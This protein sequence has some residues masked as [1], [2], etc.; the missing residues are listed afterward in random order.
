MGCAL[1][2]HGGRGGGEGIKEH[3][4]SCRGLGLRCG[5][6]SPAPCLHWGAAGA[7][8]GA[9][10]GC[11]AVV[12][13]L[14]GWVLPG[15]GWRQGWHSSGWVLAWLIQVFI[16]ASLTCLGK[17]ATGKRFAAGSIRAA[18]TASAA[19]VSNACVA[20]RHCSVKES[21]FPL[22]LLAAGSPF[23]DDVPCVTATSLC[24][25]SCVREDPRLRSRPLL[26]SPAAGLSS[27]RCGFPFAAVTFPLAVPC[28]PASP[29]H[30]CLLSLVLSGWGHCPPARQGRGQAWGGCNK[31]LVRVTL[32]EISQG[33]ISLQCLNIVSKQ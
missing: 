17:A 23:A 2:C 1:M 20:L 3:A 33:E 12:P 7:G 18:P 13:A 31:L 14:W 26:P 10:L 11:P 30:L 21:V 6:L 5:Q 16:S 29:G 24:S 8:L 32:E 19:L 15:Q 22:V 4:W 25:V 9:F 28:L 27:E